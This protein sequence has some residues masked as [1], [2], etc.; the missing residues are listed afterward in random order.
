[1]ASLYSPRLASA[2]PLSV[3]APGLVFGSICIDLSRYS[4]DSLYFFISLTSAAP[5]WYHALGSLGLIAIPVSKHL[6][7]SSYS[8][9]ATNAE[10]LLYHAIARLGLISNAILKLFIASS[11]LFKLLRVAPFSYHA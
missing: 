3:H 6:M 8:P 5:L 1:M 4:R 2:A 11:Y 9:I 10:P 7:A